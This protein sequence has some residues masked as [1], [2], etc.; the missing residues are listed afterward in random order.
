MEIFFDWTST[1]EKVQELNVAKATKEIEDEN[2]K[3]HLYVVP[4]N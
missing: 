4:Y 1:D 2:K 3:E